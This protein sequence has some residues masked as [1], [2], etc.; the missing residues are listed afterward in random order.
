MESHNAVCDWSI[1]QAAFHCMDYYASFLS[2]L[3]P[4]IN[5]RD[6]YLTKLIF[7]ILIVSYGFCY[8][9]TDLW[10]VHFMLGP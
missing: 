5:L 4:L 1:L 10:L 8:F 3:V 6:K 2:F 7:S 9:P